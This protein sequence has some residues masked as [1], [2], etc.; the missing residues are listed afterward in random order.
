MTT[1]PVAGNG[2]VDRIPPTGRLTLRSCYFMVY[3]VLS[4][5]LIVPSVTESDQDTPFEPIE[6]RTD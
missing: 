4:W 3:D 5:A 2:P 1:H 6:L